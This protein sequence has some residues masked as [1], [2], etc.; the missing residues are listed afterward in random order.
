MQATKK[1]SFI[2]LSVSLITCLSVLNSCKVHYNFRDISIPP[3][4]STVKVNLIENRASYVNV[5]LSPQLTDKLR[6]KIVSQT[7]LKQT[8]GDNADWEITGTV[9]EYSFSTSGIS[10]GKTSTNRINVAVH[11]TLTDQK[12]GETQEYNVSRS[13]DFPASQSLQQ[14]ESGKLPEMIR[15]LADD[16]FNQLFSNW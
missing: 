13:F 4:I 1:I 16:I 7:R 5:Q 6:Q 12:K 11:I 14:A 8:N 3:E 10:N 9:T 2:A 15:G